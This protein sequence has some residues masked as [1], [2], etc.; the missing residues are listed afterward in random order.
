M[1]GGM[2]TPDTIPILTAMLTPQRPARPPSRFKARLLLGT[3]ICS[4][5]VIWLAQ[6]PEIGQSVAMPAHMDH[7]DEPAREL[8]SAPAAGLPAITDGMTVWSRARVGIRFAGR[9]VPT[10]RRA[11]LEGDN[12]HSP[13]VAMPPHVDHSDE[14]ARE[15]SSGPVEPIAGIDAGKMVW[16]TSRGSARSAGRG[17]LTLQPAIMEMPARIDHDDEPE[18]ELSSGPPAGQLMGEVGRDDI[19]DYFSSRYFRDVELP[20]LAEAA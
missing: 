2:V 12:H 9:A 15:L 17:V 20:V 5:T 1:R 14:P 7:D 13:F 6:A 8:A 19:V 16:L 10:L 18:R 4:M 3:A 11:A